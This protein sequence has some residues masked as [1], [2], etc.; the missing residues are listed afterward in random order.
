MPLTPSNAIELGT[1]AQPFSLPEPLT[2]RLLGP[3]DFTEARALLVAFISNRCPYVIHIRE[4]LAQL[5]RDYDGKG[6]QI[7]AINANDA[8]AYPEEA[9]DAVAAEALKQGYIF[10]YLIDQTQEVARAYGAA[11]TPDLYLFD[12]ERKLFYHGQF[13]DSRPKNDAPV[14]GRDLRRAIDRLLVGL[15]PPAEQIQS[16]GC[17]IK[18]RE[19]ADATAS[20]N[21]VAAE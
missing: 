12:A 5:A 2:G 17:N 20:R 8:D 13:D 15:E 16:I 18:W 11:C 6:L 21:P 3:A 4:G 19:D 14:T 1:P 7:L 9:P 10:P